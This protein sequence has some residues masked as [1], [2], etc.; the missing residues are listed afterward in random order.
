LPADLRHHD[1]VMRAA[2]IADDLTGAADAGVQFVRAGHRTAVAFWEAPPPP[3]VDVVVADTDSRELDAEDAAARVA[4]VAAELRSAPLLLKKVDSTLRGPIAAEVR[5]ALEASGRSQVVFAP[6]FPAMGRTTRGGVQHVDGRPV[7]DLSGLL[8][9]DVADTETQ[10]DLVAL[11]RGVA[12]PEEV[13]W[14]GSAG[15]AAALG[16]VFPG[17]RAPAGAAPAGRGVLV[18]IGTGHP[19]AREQVRRLAGVAEDVPLGE[20]AARRAAD[21]LAGGGCAVVHTTALTAE[22]AG[23]IAGRLAS[24]VAQ[25]AGQGNVHALVLSGGETAIHVAR[26]LGASGLRIDDQLEPG[27]PVSRLVGPWP[28]P[29]VT[30]AGGFGGP[31]TLVTAVEALRGR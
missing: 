17:G 16:A 6:A 23:R 28:Y 30:K 21:V 22:D 4:A 3:D 7:A 12:D 24:V 18:A 8:G 31:M 5:A 1:A 2:V 10:E 20:H 29:V 9:C 25:V 19:T 26:A 15:L 27:V 11:V 14:V 13:L